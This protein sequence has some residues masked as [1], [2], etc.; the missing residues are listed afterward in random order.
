MTVNRIEHHLAVIEILPDIS[1][2]TIGI[3]K[4]VDGPE[5]RAGKNFCN[6]KKRRHPGRKPGKT[7]KL[8]PVNQEKQ[9][10]GIKQ[11]KYPGHDCKVNSSAG[12]EEQVFIYF[13]TAAKNQI[14]E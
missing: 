13:F 1:I 8:Q 11:E 7:E 14:I 2:R 4:R 10:S 9:C 3:V 5:R 12:K 6:K